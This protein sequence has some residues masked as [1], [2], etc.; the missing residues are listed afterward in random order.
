MLKDL[1]IANNSATIEVKVIMIKDFSERFAV[2]SMKF[3]SN[4]ILHN[5]ISHW[6]LVTVKLFTE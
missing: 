1:K 6:C 4:Q 3:G 5:K 2:S